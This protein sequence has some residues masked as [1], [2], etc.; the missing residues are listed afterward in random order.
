MVT[1]GTA[2][3]RNTRC[4]RLCFRTTF[5]FE[6]SLMCL[7]ANTCHVLYPQSPA[8]VGAAA[9][10]LRLR[11][12]QVKLLLLLLLGGCSCTRPRGGHP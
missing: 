7:Q 8:V 5:L 6:A 12:V 9:P 10:A 3:R 1:L 2:A 4:M 11:G